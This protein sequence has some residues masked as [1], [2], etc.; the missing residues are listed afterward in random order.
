MALE[1]H[2]VELSAKHRK[3]DKALH[4]ELQHPA[5]DPLKITD[6][7]KQKL[8]LK[9]EMERVRLQLQ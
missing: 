5:A 4:E 8:R 2:L 6:L 7:K 1:S 3:I 9:E